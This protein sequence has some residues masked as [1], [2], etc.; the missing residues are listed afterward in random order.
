MQNMLAHQQEK[1]GPDLIQWGNKPRVE[2]DKLPEGF[3]ALT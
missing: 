2:E 3:L 1:C